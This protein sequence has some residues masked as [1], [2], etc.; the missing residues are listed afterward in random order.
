MLDKMLTIVI[1]NDQKTAI[2]EEN[3]DTSYWDTMPNLQDINP[4]FFSI[5]AT[6][7]F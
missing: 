1:E 3:W 2:P 7:V 5:T 4:D 6:T